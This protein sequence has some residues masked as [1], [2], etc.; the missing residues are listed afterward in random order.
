MASKIVPH[1]PARKVPG[2]TP[3]TG[4]QRMLV[5]NMNELAES[6]RGEADKLLADLKEAGT[7]HGTL[8]VFGCHKETRDPFASDHGKGLNGSANRNHQ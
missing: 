4:A 5:L 3:L 2:G 6:I 7:T 1:A 8:G